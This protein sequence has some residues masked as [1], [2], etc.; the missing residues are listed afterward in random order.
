MLRVR[1]ASDYVALDPDALRRA[2]PLLAFRVVPVNLR[3]RCVVDV[4]AEGIFD[5]RQMGLV[6]VC[7]ELY[8]APKPTRY[9]R[10]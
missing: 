7:G 10:S 8:A 6:A 5:C 4:A 2:V 9:V 1:V 3:Q